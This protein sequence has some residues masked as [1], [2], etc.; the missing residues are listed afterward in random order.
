MA[1]PA[2]L[3]ILKSGVRAWNEWRQNNPFVTPDLRDLKLNRVLTIGI[4]SFLSVSSE[5]DEREAKARGIDLGKELE[6]RGF[7][8]TKP[9]FDHIDFRRA[10][11]SG[12]TLGGSL[13]GADFAS[14]NLNGAVLALATLFEANFQDTVAIEADF[15]L[16]KLR[17]ANFRHAVLQSAI[18]GMADLRDVGFEGAVLTAASL[19]DA[20]LFGANLSGAV[21]KGANLARAKLGD[22]NFGDNDLSEALGLE[23]I[24][25]AKASVVGIMTIHASRGKISANFLRGC[26]LTEVDIEFAKLGNPDL[27]NE[28]ITNVGYRIIELRST[29][30]IQMHP[31]FISYSSSDSAFVNK[32]EEKLRELGIRFWR[33]T[34]EMVAGRM[35]TQIDQAIRH[36]PTLLLVLSEASVESDWVQHEARKARELERE[37]RRDVIC[38]I[39]L[40]GSWKTCNWPE[41]LR[42]QIREYHVLDFSSWRDEEFFVRQFEKLFRGLRL[43]YNPQRNGG[44]VFIEG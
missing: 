27:T 42:E 22:T 26:G 35:E 10:D 29:Q 32:I 15:R 23:S 31:L 34:H 13:I 41:R 4:H 16:S 21:L 7:Q 2:H 17:G 5:D 19:E 6:V 24:G 11:L 1:D 36:N 33:D 18:F 3:A 40:D 9:N 14:S 20:T 12:S 8:I 25:H 37:I 44:A 30:P 43:F 39:A 28:Q 38:P